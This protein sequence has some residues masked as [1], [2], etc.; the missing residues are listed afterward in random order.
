[1]LQ[2]LKTWI[3]LVT[4]IA[5]KTKRNPSTRWQVLCTKWELKISILRLKQLDHLMNEPRRKCIFSTALTAPQRPTSPP[6]TH[7]SL[8]EQCPK[9]RL[10]AFTLPNYHTFL[11]VLAKPVVL[12]LQNRVV[13]KTEYWVLPKVGDWGRWVIVEAARRGLWTKRTGMNRY[14]IPLFIA[15]LTIAKRWKQPK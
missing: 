11:N 6:H 7:L 9:T 2:S 15:L 10:F 13:F 5:K 3:P 8:L 14:S 1:M 4:R 12:R